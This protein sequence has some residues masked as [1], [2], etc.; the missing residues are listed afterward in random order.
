M[1]KAIQYGAA[2]LLT[3]TGLDHVCEAQTLTSIFNSSLVDTLQ[4]IKLKLRCPPRTSEPQKK[5]RPACGF[6]MHMLLR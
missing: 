6:I 5:Y 4:L 2:L 1:K 3:T